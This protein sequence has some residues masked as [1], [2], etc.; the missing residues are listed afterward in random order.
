MKSMPIEAA[1]TFLFPAQHIT[2]LCAK[3]WGSSPFYMNKSDLIL[4]LSSDL[5]HSTN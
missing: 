5:L 2:Q 3:V 4:R 1:F